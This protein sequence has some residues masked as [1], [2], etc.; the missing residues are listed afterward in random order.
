[1]LRAGLLSQSLVDNF[2]DDFV[3]Y[4]DSIMNNGEAIKYI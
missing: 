1:M 2:D 3:T 4:L